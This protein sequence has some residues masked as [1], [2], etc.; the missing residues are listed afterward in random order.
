MSDSEDE[1][2]KADV[3]QG[4]KRF[5]NY[6]EKIRVEI[7]TGR[8]ELYPTVEWIKAKSESG[9]QYDCFEIS[10]VVTKEQKKKIGDSPV[11]VKIS[12]ALENN[13]KRYRLS[14]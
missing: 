3:Y 14:P 5:L 8:D 11:N 12:L 2:L 10:R 4:S 9:S 1:I 6:F 13:P 7:M